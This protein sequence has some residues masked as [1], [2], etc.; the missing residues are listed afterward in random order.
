MHALHRFKK[1]KNYKVRYESLVFQ[2]FTLYFLT[3]TTRS[4]YV[5][6]PTLQSKIIDGRL[7]PNFIILNCVHTYSLSFYSY[8]TIPY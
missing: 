6:L 7:L 2:S 5:F 8:G 3:N 4:Y 1:K